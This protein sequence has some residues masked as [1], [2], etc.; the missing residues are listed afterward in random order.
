MNG[1]R[2]AFRRYAVRAGEIQALVH[3]GPEFHSV[4]DIGKGG[5]AIA[6]TP[7][8]GKT[9]QSRAVDLVSQVGDPLVLM[10]LACR[11]VYDIDTLAEGAS[12]RGRPRRLRGLRF[13]ALTPAQEAQLDTLIARCLHRPTG[14]GGGRDDIPD[15]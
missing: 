4:R 3:P 5:L 1:E 8:P 11:T 14:G 6:Y 9:L 12:F 2:R 15:A 13:L 10:G 7:V